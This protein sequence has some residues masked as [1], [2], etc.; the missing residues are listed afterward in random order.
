MEESIDPIHVSFARSKGGKGDAKG[1]RKGDKGKVGKDPAAKR[2]HKSVS[3]PSVL[4]SFHVALLW[5]QD[6]GK[7]YG[8]KNESFHSERNDRH[9]RD[10][11]RGSFGHSLRLCRLFAVDKFALK[12][13]LLYLVGYQLRFVKDQLYLYSMKII[14]YSTG[15]ICIEKTWACVKFGRQL[16]SYVRNITWCMFFFCVC[17]F[18]VFLAC[19]F[20]YVCFSVC[21]CWWISLFFFVC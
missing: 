17:L 20:L 7:G 3:R 10:F 4:S 21:L 1:D 16:S 11:H 5:W 15:L 9:D 18:A 12:S 14:L 13:P 19:L 6:S 2:Q 8:G